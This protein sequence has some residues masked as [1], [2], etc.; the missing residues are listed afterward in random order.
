MKLMKFK[1]IKV[2]VKKDK[3][4]KKY[5]IDDVLKQ[6]TWIILDI[7]GELRIYD[8][9]KWIDEHPCGV[10]AIKKGIK[11]NMYYKD[12]KEE[13]VSPIELFM[14]NKVHADKKV[15]ENFLLKKNKYVK[16]IGYLI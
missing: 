7:K 15:M 11:A 9:T 2:K 16:L 4:L 5:N 8:L 1:N 14:G 10:A 13:P 6:E 3:K 12:K